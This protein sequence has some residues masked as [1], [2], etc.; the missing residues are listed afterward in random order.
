MAKTQVALEIT[1]TSVRA[2][3]LTIGR[4]P[5]LVAAGEVALPEGAA[6][7]SE[8]LD[9]DAVAVALQ[10]LW[11]DAR[12]SSREVVLG[13]GNRRI[14]VREHSTLLTNPAHIRQSLPFEV[15]DR[16]PVPVDQAVLDFVPTRQDEGGVHGL[17]VAAVAEHMEELVGALDHA[18]LR[19]TS[20]D[21]VAF[22]YSRALAT[23][24]PPGQTGLFLAIGEHTTHIVIATDGIPRFVR[25]VPLDIVA[26]A[27]DPVL[28]SPTTDLAIPAPPIAPTP[29]PTSTSRGER[30]RARTATGETAVPPSVPPPATAP[31][32]GF[33]AAQAPRPLHPDVQ[34][35][36]IDL[37]GRLRGTVNFFRDRPDSVPI[38][39]TWVTGTYAAHPRLLE[40]VARVMETPVT[41]VAATDLVPSGRAIAL[42]PDAGAR[43]TG[44]V[45]LL[46]GGPR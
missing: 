44:T 37:V 38:D 16:L 10:R 12:I 1:E 20:I 13:V 3:E 19:A 17:L 35:A 33:P 5:V 6:K 22:G 34:A 11:A 46:M 42:G 29:A 40:A 23:L 9:R 45:A 36:L 27:E 43:L 25:V 18:K 41:P 30:R 39:S 8:I 7:D 15:Q 21:L 14:L 28:G 26:P 32:T 4:A 24:T 2:V 31:T